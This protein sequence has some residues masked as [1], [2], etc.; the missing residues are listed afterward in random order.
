MSKAHAAE[1]AV[2][3]QSSAGV[4][5]AYTVEGMTCGHCATS[6]TEGV[7]QV[8][9]VTGIEVDLQAGR[10]VVGGDGFSDDDV[11]AAV[12]EAGYTVAGS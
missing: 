10:V 9:G 11:R 4:G 1:P 8:P 12:G 7:L 5:R 6:V 3:Q 2:A